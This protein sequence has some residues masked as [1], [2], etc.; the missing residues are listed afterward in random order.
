MALRDAAQGVAWLSSELLSLWLDSMIL[1]VFFNLK[2]SIIYSLILC[3]TTQI[4][5]VFDQNRLLIL[6][7]CFPEWLPFDTSSRDTHRLSSWQRYS[8]FCLSFFSGLLGILENSCRRKWIKLALK[9]IR[10][11]DL[12][13]FQLFIHCSVILITPEFDFHSLLTNNKISPIL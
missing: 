1:R 2:Y 13:F 11:W 10:I 12:I 4:C 6:L 8:Y 5:V 9:R 7:L 3:L